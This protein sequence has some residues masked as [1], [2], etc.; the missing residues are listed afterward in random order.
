MCGDA[1]DAICFHKR[2]FFSSRSLAS[3][4][5]CHT[6]HIITWRPFVHI[7]LMA[8]Y[9]SVIW[10][11]IS[12]KLAQKI[13]ICH[14]FLIRVTAF[15]TFFKVGNHVITKL[16][17]VSNILIVGNFGQ[18][19]EGVSIRWPYWIYCKLCDIIIAVCWQSWR[20]KEKTAVA[21]NRGCH[22]VGL[23]KPHLGY[24]NSW[25]CWYFV[26]LL[27]FWIL[28]CVEVGSAYWLLVWTCCYI[29]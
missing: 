25:D 6:S 3:A 26:L 4:V 21:V 20:D 13:T 24:Y 8:I 29:L 18:D 22:N 16:L 5:C 14:H 15:K 12:V 17:W 7:T 9:P 2:T 11:P 1:Y 19:S 23:R 28:R 27:G 10:F